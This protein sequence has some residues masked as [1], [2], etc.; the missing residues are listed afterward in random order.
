[1]WPE[2][3]ITCRPERGSGDASNKDAV[4]IRMLEPGDLK[5]A[6]EIDREVFG[7]YDPIVFTTFYEYHPRSTLVAEV[8]GSV[9]GFIL[10]F[11]HTPF[12]GRVFW[13]AVKPAYQG[14]GIGMMLLLEVLK[15]FRLMGALSA[16]LEVRA[17][18]KRA[19]SLY[20]ALGFQMVGVFPGY[21]SDG[22]AAL[23]MKRR[24]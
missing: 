11:K 3:Q 12:E 16:T 21:Y 10:G 7:G 24:L 17:S 23:I 13:L 6:L 4:V 19:Q 2:E 14:R 22:E 9:A 8:G 18:N 15:I 1:M 5:D 20:S